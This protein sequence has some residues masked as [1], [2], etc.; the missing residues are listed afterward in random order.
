MFKRFYVN[1]VSGIYL[2]HCN[3]ISQSTITV[4]HHD[5]TCIEHSVAEHRHDENKKHA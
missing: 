1:I 4:A 5:I 2:D 3:I